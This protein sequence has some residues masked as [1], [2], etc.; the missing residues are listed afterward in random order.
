MTGEAFDV[1]FDG[2]IGPTHTYGGLALG[3]V[4]SLEHRGEI[5]NPRNAALQGLEKMKLLADLGL[6]QAVLPPHE[7][8]HLRTLRTLGFSG[9]DAQVIEKAYRCEPRLLEACSS[10]SAMWTAN[11][12]TVSPSAD[13]A[14]GR[15]H[16]TP[17][18]LVSQFHRSLEPPQTARVLKAIFADENHFAHHAPLPS[19]PHLGDEGAAN[20]IRL[21]DPCG[22][23]GIEVFVYG[24][25]SLAEGRQP[26]STPRTKFPARQKLEASR[27]IARIH[28]LAPDHSCFIRQN[29]AAI[30]SGVFHND[31]I[32]VGNR[33]V[34]L[35][36]QFAF[37]NNAAAIEE[38]RRKFEAST[39][40]PLVTVEVESEEL[41]LEEVVR[42]YFFNSQLVT[43]P[44]G[45]M[46]MI[47]PQE[48]LLTRK[49]K[50]LLD[51][52]A[53]DPL[54]P[55][56][57]VYYVDIRQSMKNGGG[58]ACLRL[59]MVLNEK[60][61]K[62]CH[63][64]VFLDQTLYAN[65]KAWIE[66]HYREELSARDLAD[67]QLLNESRTALDEV[68]QILHLTDIFDG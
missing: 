43:L 64:G 29:R 17:A 11:A 15:V 59:G 4:A 18:N 57:N 28:G 61:R 16:F 66:K 65:L 22:T 33:N 51:R 34:F 23:P 47:C 63:Q 40:Q 19:A 53:A 25:E 21:C 54:N 26:K 20:H 5:S 55:I 44:N 60:E 67:P 27:A 68:A 10:A 48:C 8:P 24:E 31:V 37:E 42:T 50:S 58:P 62:A 9:T 56:T 39:G 30:D 7:R 6:H 49:T 38:I 1:N 35:F 52:I 46:A 13:A 2:I 32:S 3:N 45:S 12:A 36:H 41:P 14:D